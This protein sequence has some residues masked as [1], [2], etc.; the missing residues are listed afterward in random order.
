MARS[1]PAGKSRAARE[2]GTRGRPI[3]VVNGRTSFVRKDGIWKAMML[4]KRTRSASAGLL[5]GWARL[6]VIIVW[7]YEF[8]VEED[9]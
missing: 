5:K 2:S 9:K 3:E 8:N 4:R 6:W 1:V 7:V